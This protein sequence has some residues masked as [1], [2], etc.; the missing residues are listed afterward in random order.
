[1]LGEL[2]A[3]A[4]EGGFRRQHLGETAAGRNLDPS[5]AGRGKNAQLEGDTGFQ[6]EK[7]ATSGPCSPTRTASFRSPGVEPLNGHPRGGTHRE[8]GLGRVGFAGELAAA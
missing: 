2:K 1:M 8:P 4:G 6:E 3:W 7:T 5:N